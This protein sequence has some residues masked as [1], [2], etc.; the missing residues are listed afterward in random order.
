MRFQ[1]T[2]IYV[3]SLVRL[4]AA[5][6]VD[7]HK[8]WRRFH[9]GVKLVHKCQ[10]MKRALRGDHHNIERVTGGYRI[11]FSREKLKSA[12]AERNGTKMELGCDH[13]CFSIR[14]SKRDFVLLRVVLDE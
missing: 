12:L 14:L 1:I 9:N 4:S 8:R 10:S 11:S 3:G 2:C 5:A 6:I 7:L 13:P